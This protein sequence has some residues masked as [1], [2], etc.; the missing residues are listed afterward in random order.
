MRVPAG[1][2]DVTT[3]FKLVDP[4]SGDE[5]TGLTITDL[6][7]TYVRD[8]AT[9]VKADATALTAADDAHADN[10]MFEVDGTN[11]PG[12]YRADWPDAAFTAGVDKVQLVVKGAAID[13]AVQEVEIGPAPADMVEVSGDSTAADNLESILD[14]NGITNDIDLTM[15]SLTITNDAGVGLAVTGTTDGM[16]ATGT[17]GSGIKASSSGSNGAGLE[18]AGNGSGPGLDIDAGA[19]GAGVDIDATSGSAVDLT[20]AAGS[21]LK[22]SGTTHGAEIA[23]SA[24]PGVEIDGTTFGMQVDA[25]AGPGFHIGGTT[26]GIEATASAGPAFSCVASAGNNS[27][28]VATKSGSGYDIDA[29]INGTISTV[30]TLT[31]HTAQTGDSYAIVNSGSYG[32]SALKTLIDGVPTTAEFEAR[33]LVAANYGTAA[34]Q[35]AIIGYIDTEIGTIITAVGTTLENHLTDIKGTGFVKDTHSLPQCLTATGFAVAGNA[36]AL[37]SGERTTLADVILA[38]DVSNAEPASNEHTLRFSILVMTESNLVDNA[39][40]LTVYKTDGVTEVAQKDV[41]TDASADPV[42][43]VS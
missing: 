11:T 35:T 27:G 21:A 7:M 41:T 29:D 23:A 8:R 2:T 34:N 9:A 22:L 36:M 19:T 20:T 28:I 26:F 38:R 13:T 24:G 40:K 17:A 32:N 37:T 18:L 6:D 14:G 31:G 42:T 10:K 43:G 1:A 4:T 3:Y 15:R 33:T 30:T 25:S 39:N 5:E 12:M 16:T